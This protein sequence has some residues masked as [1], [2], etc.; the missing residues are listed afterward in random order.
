MPSRRSK[1]RHQRQLLRS[2]IRREAHEVVGIT[3]LDGTLI[4][5]FSSSLM[6]RALSVVAPGRS[7]QSISACPT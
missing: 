2:Q 3:P 1:N 6:R 4:L 5:T 7:P